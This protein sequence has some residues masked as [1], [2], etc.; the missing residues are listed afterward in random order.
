VLLLGNALLAI[1]FIYCGVIC[2]VAASDS[3]ILTH[4]FLFSDIIQNGALSSLVSMARAA[5]YGNLRLL[6]TKILRVISE[7]YA[8]HIRQLCDAE[9][10]LALGQILRGDIAFI[11]SSLENSQAASDTSDLINDSLSNEFLTSATSAENMLNEVRHV[12]CGLVNILHSSSSSPSTGTPYGAS[13]AFQDAQLKACSQIIASGGIKS[14]LWIASLTEDACSKLEMTTRVPHLCQDIQVDSWQAL[15]SLCPLLLAPNGLTSGTTQWTPYVLSALMNVLKA[16][17]FLGLIPEIYVDVLQGL[18][19]LADCEPLK[20]RIIDEFLPHLMELHRHGN[21]SV[22]SATT[23]VCLALGF[24]EVE[25]GAND[26]YLLGDKFVLARSRLVQAMAR[27]EIRQVLK[28]TWMPSKSADAQL[29]ENSEHSYGTNE[30]G[31]LFASLCQDADT[32]GLR[33]KVRQQF[34]SLYDDSAAPSSPHRAQ[35]IASLDRRQ[36]LRTVHRTV[37]RTSSYV[38]AHELDRFNRGRNCPPPNFPTGVSS[39]HRAEDM[40]FRAISELSM[41]SSGKRNKVRHKMFLYATCITW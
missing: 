18:G 27:E 9:A 28:D 17:S 38:E 16:Q 31:S 20:T 39:S 23:Q 32:A 3:E 34:M 8:G 26:A 29:G 4:A 41:S 25:S 6:S 14:L 21:Q 40:H 15:A 24:N 33:E 1:V 30:V 12:L 5:C 13:A 2:V 36:V 22:S 37:H 10:V 11:R 35:S 19:C 7:G